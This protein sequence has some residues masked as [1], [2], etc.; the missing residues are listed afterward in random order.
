MSFS[1]ETGHVETL[2]DRRAFLSPDRPIV[3]G[4]FYVAGKGIPIVLRERGWFYDD[5]H[6]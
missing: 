5:P 3:A 6:A 4:G 2:P 1:E